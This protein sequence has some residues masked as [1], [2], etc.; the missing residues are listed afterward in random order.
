[1][2]IEVY[3]SYMPMHPTHWGRQLHAMPTVFFYCLA[4]VRLVSRTRISLGS[5]DKP[6]TE[7]MS[8]PL[9]GENMM[10]TL[11]IGNKKRTTSVYP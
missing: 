10:N 9:S 4:S 11:Q 8:A 1:M 6:T 7:E 3:Y 5:T 2:T